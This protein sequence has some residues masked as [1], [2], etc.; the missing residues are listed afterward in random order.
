MNWIAYYYFVTV[1]LCLYITS[2]YRFVFQKD[3]V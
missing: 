1:A 3:L 2:G